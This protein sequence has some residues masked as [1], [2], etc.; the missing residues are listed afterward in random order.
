MRTN[1]GRTHHMHQRYTMELES[2]MGRVMK[3]TALGC[4]IQAWH[5]GVT[6]CAHEGLGHLRA[7]EGL[8]G[9]WWGRAWTALAVVV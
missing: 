1:R 6:V 5:Q 3:R 8:T 9:G 7:V 4:G 2:V